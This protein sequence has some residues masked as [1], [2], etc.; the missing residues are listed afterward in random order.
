MPEGD[1]IEAKHFWSHLGIV[2]ADVFQ[3]I[4]GGDHCVS[5]VSVV[6]CADEDLGDCADKLVTDGAD[7]VGEIVPLLCFKLEHV[8]HAGICMR[9]GV[10]V[11]DMED[12][13]R[14]C[15][16]VVSSEVLEFL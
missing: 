7:E 16:P 3:E 10:T 14:W 13:E 11:V 8:Q 2:V 9:W 12:G 4:D 1:V 15:D 6:E 5:S